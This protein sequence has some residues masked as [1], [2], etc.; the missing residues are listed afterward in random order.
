[1]LDVDFHFYHKLLILIR[2]EDCNG[3]I[4]LKEEIRL[5]TINS[6]IVKE[7]NLTFINAVCEIYVTFSLF[8]NLNSHIKNKFTNDCDLIEKNKGHH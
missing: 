3:I 4:K 6:N 2:T 7:R 1:V 5:P 8:P